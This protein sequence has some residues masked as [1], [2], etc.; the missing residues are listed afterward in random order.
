MAGFF[1]CAASGLASV[2]KDCEKEELESVCKDIKTRTALTAL[3]N[4]ILLLA[5]ATV[6]VWSICCGCKYGHY[7]GVER[8]CCAVSRPTRNLIEEPPVKISVR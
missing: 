8:R 1:V 3:T 7:F 6:S 2:L 5:S 4:M